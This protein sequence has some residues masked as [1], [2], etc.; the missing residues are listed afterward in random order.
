MSGVLIIIAW[1]AITLLIAG[2][3]T[4]LGKRYS[5]VFPIAAMACLIVIANIVASKF[6]VFGPFTVSAGVIAISSTFFI[7]DILSE[8]WGKKTAQLAVWVG[9]FCN[10]L[11]VISVWIVIAWPAADFSLDYATKFKEVLGPTPRIVLASMTAYLISQHH[12]IWAFHFWKKKT[13]GKLLWLRNNASTIVS[14]FID[15]II[16]SVIAFVGVLATGELIAIIIGE[17]IVK[18][19]I[20]LLDTP[21]MYAIVKIIDKIP[22]KNL[23]HGKNSLT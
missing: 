19:I 20:A 9:F 8:K 3:S 22:N 16:F 1:F 23:T 5:V 2:F 21:F 14:Q 6:V 18:V 12:D 15:I 10:L 17:Y 4:V 13:N 7:T 11:L